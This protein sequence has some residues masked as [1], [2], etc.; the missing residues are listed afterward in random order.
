MSATAA[1][2]KLLITL[3][4]AATEREKQA[5]IDEEYAQKKA[6]FAIEERAQAEALRVQAAALEQEMA[7]AKD[8]SVAEFAAMNDKHASTVRQWIRT[9]KVRWRRIGNEYRVIGFREGE[10]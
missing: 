7:Q 9:E 1:A 5:Q 10:R 4:L 6:R 3:R 8:Y 2:E